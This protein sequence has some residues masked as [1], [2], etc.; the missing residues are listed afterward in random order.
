MSLSGSTKDTSEDKCLLKEPLSGIIAAGDRAIKMH[1][2]WAPVCVSHTVMGGERCLWYNPL[3][4]TNLCSPSLSSL[5][6]TSRL[7]LSIIWSSLC[8]SLQNKSLMEFLLSLI[9]IQHSACLCRLISLS[10]THSDTHTHL[11]LLLIVPISHF[12]STF[13]SFSHKSSSSGKKNTFISLF[14]SS[15][16][17]NCN[18]ETALYTTF[19]KV[20]LFFFLPSGCK[21]V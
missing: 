5:L 6:C 16:C 9:S 19:F 10:H 14:I 1:R 18:N 21:C 12:C 20:G 15:F 11:S 8:L 13:F 7:P 17:C 4:D 3:C 2:V